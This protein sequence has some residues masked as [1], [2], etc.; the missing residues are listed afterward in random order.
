MQ[1]C[2]TSKVFGDVQSNLTISEVKLKHKFSNNL[3]VV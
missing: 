1:Y 3:L 2:I